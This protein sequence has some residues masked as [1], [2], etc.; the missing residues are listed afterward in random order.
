MHLRAGRTNR[1][2]PSAPI[3]VATGLR[4]ASAAPSGAFLSSGPFR[5]TWQMER[6][7][8]TDDSAAEISWN[9]YFIPFSIARFLARR[10]CM[11]LLEVCAAV[12]ASEQFAGAMAQWRISRWHRF[13]KIYT[14]WWQRIASTPPFDDFVPGNF[15]ASM[16]AK[17]C[18]MVQIN[19]H[20]LPIILH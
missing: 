12:Y 10:S 14:P 11:I 15:R 17:L 5:H 8:H 13:R 1:E 20:L 19:Q 7:H 18:P 16:S 9:Y 6:V 4:P 3:R 2:C